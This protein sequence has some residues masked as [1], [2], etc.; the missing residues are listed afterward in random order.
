[1]TK[2]SFL[3]TN[4]DGIHSNGLVALAGEFSRLGEVYVVAPDREQSACG[5]A[6]TLNHPLRVE[7]HKVDGAQKAW[8]VDGTPADGVKL[9]VEVPLMPSPPDFVIS[10]INRGPN[11]GTDVLYSGTVSAAFEALLSGFPAV[12]VSLCEP[13]DAGYAYSA[14]VA[15]RLVR[16]W[17]E[18]PLPPDTLLNVNIPGVEVDQITGIALT[19]L[20]RRKYDRVFERR[21]DPRGRVYYWMAGEPLEETETGTDV[22][23]I[24]MNMVSITPLHFDLTRRDLL[25]KIEQWLR[26]LDPS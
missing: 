1:M 2:T 17:M 18:N 23:A 11:L 5:H 12:A 9:A 15:S 10:G 22:A 21:V 14:K 20:G 8:A 24:R 19:W 16:A 7:E 13:S 26:C 4:D 3:I 25:E 6:I